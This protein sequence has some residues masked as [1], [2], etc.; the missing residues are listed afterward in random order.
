MN[1]QLVK[2]VHIMIML[3]TVEKSQGRMHKIGEDTKSDHCSFFSKEETHCTLG[4]AETSVSDLKEGK[5]R[6][7]RKRRGGNENG[8]HHRLPRGVYTPDQSHE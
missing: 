1:T 4:I 8:G 6:R 7:R 3:N 2:I 5:A